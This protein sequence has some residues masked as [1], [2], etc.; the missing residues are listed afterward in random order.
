MTDDSFDAMSIICCREAPPGT[1]SVEQFGENDGFVDSLQFLVVHVVLHFVRVT[2]YYTN[3]MV[4][5]VFRRAAIFLSITPKHL[6]GQ[7]AN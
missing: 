7:L 6:S 1:G 3:R 5:K 4:R 2:N